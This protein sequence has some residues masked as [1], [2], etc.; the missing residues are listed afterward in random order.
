MTETPVC[1]VVLA[2]NRVNDTVACIASLLRSTYARLH[3]LLCDNGSTD[4]TA[5]AVRSTFSQVEVLELR[6]NLGFAAGAN[7]GIRH[8]LAAGFEQVLLVNNDTIVDEAML[9]RMMAFAAPDVGLLAP[10]VFYAGQPDVIWSAGGLRSP[11][12]LEQTNDVRGRRREEGWGAVLER[13]FV[14]GCAMLLSKIALEAVGLF[15]ERFFMY[16]EDSDLCLRLRRSGFRLLLVPDARMWHEVAASSGGSDS[17]VERYAMARS[18]VIFFRKYV[19]GWQWG[20]VGP[21]RLASAV[22]TT[23]RL[24]IRGKPTAARAYWRGLTDG[25]TY[26]HEP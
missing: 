14:P 7:V 21:Y 13:D 26:T 20:I 2:W 16:Y 24:L 9:E 23:M 1:A 15:D 17:P 25:F 22:K 19:H 8:A 4:G 12:T 11:W 18:S 5:G 10:L 3:V 6:Q